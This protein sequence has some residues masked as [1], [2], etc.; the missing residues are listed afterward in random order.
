MRPTTSR[1][2]RRQLTA[3][4]ILLLLLPGSK[5]VPLVAD[6]NPYITRV[7]RVPLNDALTP[8]NFARLEAKSATARDVLAR[9]ELVPDAIFIVQA[10]PRL[11]QDERLLGRGRFWV[12]QDRLFGVL[13]YQAEPAGS[14]RALRILAHELAH[15]LEVGMLP[16]SGGTRVLRARLELRDRDGDVDRA[17]G[18]E[19]DFA[20]AVAYR[21]R[22]ELLGRL[23]NSTELL[24]QAERSHV[25]I[26]P[27]AHDVT[28]VKR[29]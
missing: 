10:H 8:G 22:L 17:P 21:V 6:G 5:A 24:A 7:V 11:V 9:L 14:P 25:V 26:P 12:V 4:F 18:I 2:G 3:T 1:V 23:P 20:R 13:E 28:D 27:R 16:R 19:T 29:R 15:A